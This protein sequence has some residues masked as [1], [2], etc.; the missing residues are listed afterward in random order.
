MVDLPIAMLIVHRK[1]GHFTPQSFQWWF[2][3]RCRPPRG[4]RSPRSDYPSRALVV[5]NAWKAH[6]NDVPV[7]HHPFI[8]GFLS[9]RFRLGHFN[10]GF[11]YV[12]QAGYVGRP[13]VIK[14]DLVP[15]NLL[16]SRD[17][18][19]EAVAE[20][21]SHFFC[22]LTFHR[23]HAYYD[24]LWMFMVDI[25]IVNGGV[26]MVYKPYVFAKQKLHRHRPQIEKAGTDAN[27]GAKGYHGKEL[28][29]AR[30]WN[31]RFP[32]WEPKV[33]IARNCR[34]PEVRIYVFEAKRLSL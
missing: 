27:V 9:T 28:P 16:W 4:E 30:P 31:L 22:V 3:E 7:N 8:A 21:R 19:G 32:T 10:H 15:Q 18:R 5:E 33:T 34:F 12:Y 11:L 29:V 14:T 24:G 25:T 1:L 13:E 20:A 23:G 6:V 2:G 26:I 17:V